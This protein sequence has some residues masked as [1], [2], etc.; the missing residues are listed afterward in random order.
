MSDTGAGIFIASI[1]WA[2]AWLLTGAFMDTSKQWAVDRLSEGDKL[3]ATHDGL[4]SF[5]TM[6]NYTCKDNTIIDAPFGAQEK[7][8]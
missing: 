5:D 4:N 8:P 7:K 3:C 6:R 1:F 2:T